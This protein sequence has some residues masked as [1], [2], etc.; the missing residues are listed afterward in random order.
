MAEVAGGG[1]GGL[2]HHCFGDKNATSAYCAALC[3]YTKQAFTYIN[4]WAIVYVGRRASSYINNKRAQGLPTTLAG[5][6]FLLDIPMT[7]R[8]TRFICLLWAARS[9]VAGAVLGSTV[10][11]VNL[12]WLRKGSC[13]KPCR[14]FGKGVT[15]QLS[16]CI[17]CGNR[18]RRT[19]LWHREQRALEREFSLLAAIEISS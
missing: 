18:N 14:V 10:H 19:K 2:M 3:I 8:I 9:S 6:A 12:A 7:T 11:L 16:L 1:G 15:N 17:R 13:T 5:R 4:S